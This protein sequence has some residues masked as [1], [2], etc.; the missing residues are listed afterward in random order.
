LISQNQACGRHRS[1]VG[2]EPTATLADLEWADGI[3]FG[4]PT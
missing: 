4:T 1:E 3:A 2:E